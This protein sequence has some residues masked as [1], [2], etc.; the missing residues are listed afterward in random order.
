M[1]SV[2]P[3]VHECQLTC[4]NGGYC[5]YISNKEATLVEIFASGGMIEKCVCPPGYTGI[6]CEIIAEECHNLKC[7][8]GTPCFMIEGEPFCDCSEADA[9]SKFAGH[10]C[11]EPATSY[12]GQGGLKNR[13]FCTNGGLCKS[14]LS[15]HSGLVENEFSTHS[16]CHCPPEFEGPHCEYLAGTTPISSEEVHL[17]VAHE[18]PTNDGIKVEAGIASVYKNESMNPQESGAGIFASVAILFGIALSIFG[19]AIMRRRKRFLETHAQM[20]NMLDRESHHDET[21]IRVKIMGELETLDHC[22]NGYYDEDD[23][24]SIGECS[25]EE[26]ELED[27]EVASNYR[28]Y[29]AQIRDGGYETYFETETDFTKIIGPLAKRE[30][31]TAKD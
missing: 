2:I 16:G 18:N 10:M 26:I 8:N 24:H 31:Q 19:V 25:L 29:L 23:L 1:S 7:R 17:K 6:V 14:N 22:E 11:R 28:E 15:V 20:A 5:T 21:P 12:C 30:P 13:G 4:Q 27:N 9:V 3:P